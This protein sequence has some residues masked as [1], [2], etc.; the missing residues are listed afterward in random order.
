M[1]R[2]LLLSNDNDFLELM[3]LSFEEKFGCEVI[4]SSSGKDG[5]RQLQR[6][7]DFDV[8]VSDY[9]YDSLELLRFK[10]A[11]N[12]IIP[13]FFFTDE[14]KIEAIYSPKSFVGIFRKNQFELLCGSIEYILRKK[15]RS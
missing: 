7:V 13:Y 4:C 10:I 8:I 5:I 12:I 2:L 1:G 9:N 3:R 14:R 6:R 15:S 11:S